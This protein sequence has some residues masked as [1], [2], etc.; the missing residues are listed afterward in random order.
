[1]PHLLLPP[2]PPE[3]SEGG[4]AAGASP[5]DT[6]PGGSPLWRLLLRAAS[7]GGPWLTGLL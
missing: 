3:V 4:T 1:L 2:P 6:G 7:G 5:V